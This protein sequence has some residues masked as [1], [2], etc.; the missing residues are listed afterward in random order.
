[1]NK[2]LKKAIINFLLDNEKEFQLHNRTMDE[3]RLYIFNPQGEYI[4]GGKDV[5]DFIGEAIRLLI[6]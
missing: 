4:I 2:E 6:K 5:Y 3:F 1:M